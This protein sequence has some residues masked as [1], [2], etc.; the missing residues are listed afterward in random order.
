MASVKS[1]ITAG[2]LAARCAAAFVAPG[3]SYAVT[4]LRGSTAVKAESSFGTHSAVT[5]FVGTKSRPPARPWPAS[6]APGHG[7]ASPSPWYSL[8]PPSSAR[9][10][11]PSRICEPRSSSTGELLSLQGMLFLRC[12]FSTDAGTYI[13][14]RNEPG[15]SPGLAMMGALGMLTQSLVQLPGME[16]VPKDKFGLQHRCRPNRLFH[17]HRQHRGV[18]GGR[19][20]PGRQQGARQVGSHVRCAYRG[21]WLTPFIFGTFNLVTLWLNFACVVC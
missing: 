18:G 4:S 5:S 3:A 21:W 11:L 1:M 9:T 19:L 10:R 13:I 17:H 6:S 7:L 2:L 16:G 8:N 12:C 15:G 14:Y 20:R